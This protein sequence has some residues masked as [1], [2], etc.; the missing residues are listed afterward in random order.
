MYHVTYKNI[1]KSNKK[2][3]DYMRWLKIHW[4]MQQKWGATSVK[5]W[6]SDEGDKRVVFCR[7]TVEDIYYW[8][9]RAAEPEAKTLVEALSEVVDLDQMSV[10]ITVPSQQNA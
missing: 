5:L 7:Y 6:N 9:R 3:S 8:N 2:R 1:L 4:P 10:K